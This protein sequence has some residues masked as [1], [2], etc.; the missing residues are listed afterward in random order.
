M[1]LSSESIETPFARK[2]PL[3]PA[4][5]LRR[6]PRRRPH[7]VGHGL[8]ESLRLKISRAKSRAALPTSS[9]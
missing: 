3:M 8:L 7:A 2:I 1:S 6:G 4:P 5:L 9:R